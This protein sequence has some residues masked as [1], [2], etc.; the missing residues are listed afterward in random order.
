L[1]NSR[2]SYTSCGP[3]L[4]PDGTVL[5]FHHPKIA[6]KTAEDRKDDAL[7]TEVPQAAYIHL[8]EQRIHVNTSQARF[9]SNSLIVVALKKRRRGGRRAIAD[10]LRSSLADSKPLICMHG[11]LVRCLVDCAGAGLMNT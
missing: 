9:G 10:K 6:G 7:A 2:K 11:V 3:A 4:L 1:Q 8:G 5:S